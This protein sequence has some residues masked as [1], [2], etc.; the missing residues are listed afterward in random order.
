M[1]SLTHTVL[2]IAAY[3]NARKA[4]NVQTGNAKDVCINE[5]RAV[6]TAAQADAKLQRTSI[7]ANAAIGAGVDKEV[8]K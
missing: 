5:A 6:N 7:K 2:A 8:K 4:C 3:D 1:N